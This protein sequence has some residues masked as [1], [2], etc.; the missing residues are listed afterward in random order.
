ME[1]KKTPQVRQEETLRQKPSE[2]TAFPR[3]RKATLL[4][5]AKG[6]NSI[7]TKKGPFCTM[8]CD[9]LVAMQTGVKGSLFPGLLE[10]QIT[11][12]RRW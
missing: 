11:G 2:D 8:M 3:N 6:V 9:F 7:R 5:A 12:G 1:T 10:E 4:S